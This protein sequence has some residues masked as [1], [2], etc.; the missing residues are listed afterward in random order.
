MG[1][2]KHVLGVLDSK[3]GLDTKNVPKGTTQTQQKRLQKLEADHQEKKRKVE[4]RDQIGAGMVVISR[5]MLY[6]P[7]QFEEDKLE[8]LELKLME[9][10]EDGDQAKIK[11]YTERV[12]F[13]QNRVEAMQEE[14]TAMEGN[15]EDNKKK[16]N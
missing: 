12:E 11:F 3:V 6:Q 14:I 10:K 13:R 8:R 9:A 1:V 5:A 7:L 16:N 2:L 15:K 4:F